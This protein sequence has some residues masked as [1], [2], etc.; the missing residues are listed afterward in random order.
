VYW[1]VLTTRP[2]RAGDTLAAAATARYT[3]APGQAARGNQSAVQKPGTTTATAAQ[4]K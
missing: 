3:A 1:V 4:P 2:S